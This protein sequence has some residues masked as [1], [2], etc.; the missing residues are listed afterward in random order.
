MC[1]LYLLWDQS[2]PADVTA[3]G[4]VYFKEPPQPHGPAEPD[5]GPARGAG[6]AGE[7]HRAGNYMHRTQ[8]FA[9]SS[10]ALSLVSC[11]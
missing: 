2:Q 6:T 3:S 9:H 11:V 1:V 4:G 5:G 7:P 10:Q 8:P